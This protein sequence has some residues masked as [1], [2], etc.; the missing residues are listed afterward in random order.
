V[1]SAL[2]LR[3]SHKYTQVYLTK[4]FPIGLP[5]KNNLAGNSTNC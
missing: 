5:V 1:Y 3:L 4:L 2:E